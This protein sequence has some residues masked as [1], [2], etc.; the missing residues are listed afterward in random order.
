MSYSEPSTTFPSKSCPSLWALYH[1]A[2]ASLSDIISYQFS[3]L[4]YSPATLTFLESSSH[5]P[6]PAPLYLLILLPKHVSPECHVLTPSLLFG[7][8]PNAA[9]F[10]R[11]SLTILPEVAPTPSMLWLCFLHGL[12]SLHIL[13]LSEVI[14]CVCLSSESHPGKETSSLI[15]SIS[16]YN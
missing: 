16:P 3:F 10:S 15:L 8:F 5:P 9:F 6:P 2:P 14:L 13:S 12:D 11:P 4:R 7:L 1:Q